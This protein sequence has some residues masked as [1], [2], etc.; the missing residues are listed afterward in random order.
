MEILKFYINKPESI[1]L[2]VH[3]RLITK[4]FDRFP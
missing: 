2:T 4:L 3:F 1:V